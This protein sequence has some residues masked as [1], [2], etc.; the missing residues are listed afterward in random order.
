MER[1]YNCVT[2][3]FNY[4]VVNTD[5]APVPAAWNA[6]NSAN[7]GGL[8]APPTNLDGSLVFAGVG[9]VSPSVSGTD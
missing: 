1:S 3:A 2:T 6:I 9:G 8:P 4:N 7:P 5:S